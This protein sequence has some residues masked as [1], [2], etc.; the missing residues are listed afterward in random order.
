MAVFRQITQIT[1]LLTFLALEG[2]ASSH[3][4]HQKAGNSLGG[5]TTGIP[6][7]VNVP[8]L[9]QSIFTQ[10]TYSAVQLKLETE[11]YVSPDFQQDVLQSSFVDWRDR[12]FLSWL[13]S[14][15][16][17]NPC[18]SCWA[19]ATAAL[20]EAQVRIEHGYW[21]KRSEGDIRDGMLSSWIPGRD[22]PSTQYCAQGASVTDGLKYA[23]LFGV[24]D[25]GCFPTNHILGVA[26]P[27][28]PCIDKL[29]RSTLVP[30]WTEL[31]TAEDQ[32][33]W[34]YN[35]G[36]IIASISFDKQNILDDFSNYAAGTIYKAPTP[37]PSENYGGGHNPL[38]VGYNDLEGYWIIKNS[39]GPD[40]GD[41]G[42][43]FIAYGELSIDVFSKEGLQFTNP[44][45][46]VKRRLHNGNM[47][48]K[49]D[50]LVSTST[51]HKEFA[52]AVCGDDTIQFLVRGDGF[53][54]QFPWKDVG[55]YASIASF[56]PQN[57]GQCEGQPTLTGVAGFGA[58][59]GYELLYWNGNLN[60]IEHIRF[61]DA[62]NSWQ[63]QPPFGAGA[64]AGYPALIQS[65]YGHPGN[66][67]AVVRHV[68]GSMNHWA[69][70]WPD[71]SA[72]NQIAEV[73]PPG[74]ILMS[75]PSLV[76]SNAGVNGNFYIVAVAVDGSL[77]MYWRDNDNPA[78]L[79]WFAGESFASNVAATSP[80]M[81]QTTKDSDDENYIGDFDVLV[82][83][84]GVVSHYRR[85]N[86][87]L[88][89]GGRPTS[90]QTGPWSLVDTFGRSEDNYFVHVRSFAQ[91]PFNQ[92]LEAAVVNSFGSLEWWFYSVAD[93]KWESAGGIPSVD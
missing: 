5:N 42:Y 27:Y 24:T 37:D 76:Q 15:Q 46:W 11:N 25:L 69:R 68:D 14:V 92:N 16:D 62:G 60:Q 4:H 9:N 83:V 65:N 81:I 7:A 26:D 1:F 82:V 49:G 32:K 23:N 85:N 53:N 17:Q 63:I 78:A 51:T 10:I 29:G 44:D 31:G 58:S 36:P 80:V 66:L 59:A 73:A 88:R 50:D 13:T 61:E 57:R 71:D 84:Q 19:Y 35:V 30:A 79:D 93:G 67:E 28:T 6:L 56:E 8:R 54:G 77:V 89:K 41:Q 86:S 43:G 87:D 33:N 12:Y 21:A 3:S 70:A 75:G 38:I 22:I 45:S 2:L 18:G 39:W 72:W 48:H 55:R 34:I 74:S 20:I 91:G 90:G 47:I 52:L 40:W 64:T